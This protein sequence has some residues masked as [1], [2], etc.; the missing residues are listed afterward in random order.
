MS[1]AVDP[2]WKWKRL[3]WGMGVSLV[4]PLEVRNP[5]ELALVA[6]LVKSLVLRETTLAE[7]FPGYAYDRVDWVA[8]QAGLKAPR[9]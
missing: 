6:K 9:S 7:Q 8:E 1:L 5:Q 2:S 3:W 4:V